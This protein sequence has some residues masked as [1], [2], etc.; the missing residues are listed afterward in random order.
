MSKTAATVTVGGPVVWRGHKE[1]GTVLAMD[2]ATQTAA[3]R[4][5]RG[6][7]WTVCLEDL[8]PAP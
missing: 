6:E 4:D 2:A 3:V 8:R 7:E 5:A 1:R